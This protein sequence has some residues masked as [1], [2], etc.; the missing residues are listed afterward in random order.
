M[1][2]VRESATQLVEG[3]QIFGNVLGLP[4]SPRSTSQTSH[5]STI[6][7]KHRMS[8][9][10]RVAAPRKKTAVDRFVDSPVFNI[11][12]NISIIASALMLGVQSEISDSDRRQAL[13]KVFEHFFTAVF[14]FEMVLKIASSPSRYFKDP[15][16][17]LDFV[18]AWVSIVSS[19]ILPVL[20]IQSDE[21]MGIVRVFRLL[22]LLRILKIMKS[23]PELRMVV[24][25]LVGSLRALFWVVLLLLMVVYGF[26]I[27]FVEMVGRR[28]DLYP[29]YD[30][31]E[32][33]ITSAL[34]FMNYNCYE[35]FGSVQRSMMTLFSI[36]LLAEWD[37]FRPI[38]EFQ[39]WIVPIFLLLIFVTS[40]GIVNVIIGVIVERTTSSMNEIH[41]SHMEEMK[42]QKMREI[43][44]IANDLWL[45]DHDG[46]GQ[47]SKDEMVSTGEDQAMLN[48]FRNLDFPKGFTFEDLF[49]M[50]N[51]DGCGDMTRKEFEDG[52][53]RI[54]FGSEFQKTCLTLLGMGQIKAMSRHLF[55]RQKEHLDA[56]FDSLQANLLKLLESFAPPPAP[57]VPTAP[58]DHVLC[59]FMPPQLPHETCDFASEGRVLASSS[60]TRV[61]KGN[62]RTQPPELVEVPRVSVLDLPHSPPSLDQAAAF[63]R[64]PAESP[65]RNVGGCFTC[66][67]TMPSVPDGPNRDRRQ[68]LSPVNGS[69]QLP[70]RS[71]CDEL[72]F[73]RC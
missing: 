18:I 68:D 2:S 4:S 61:S 42:T 64:M 11:A 69:V 19:W 53:H 7:V 17:Y 20:R 70:S 50:L 25:G 51:L 56:R 3:L 60:G 31:S 35:Y 16:C 65:G 55:S 58:V 52:M 9:G 10:P 30:T 28:S 6:S 8:M 47:I 49:E 22:R 24:E 66:P 62:L 44:R 1:S 67:K 45:S 12:I 40:F 48:H 59:S 15:W 46:N 43:R 54:I 73:N 29:G 38:W 36:S 39:A 26:A 33:A 57:N 32:E 72:R 34:A 13:W 21:R 14:A 41:A 63:V 27:F 37:S 23:I 71:G 5:H